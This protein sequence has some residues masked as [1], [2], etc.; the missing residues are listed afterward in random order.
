MKARTGVGVA[1]SSGS[2]LA[3]RT[4]PARRAAAPGVGVLAG[5]ATCSTG[6]STGWSTGCSTGCSSTRGSACRA[7][8]RSMAGTAARIVSSRE[9]AAG[10][11]VRRAW[12]S[13]SARTAWAWRRERDGA[14]DGRGEQDLRDLDLDLGLRRVDQSRLE[15]LQPAARVDG[16]GNLLGLRL[17]RLLADRAHDDGLPARRRLT[18][19][20]VAGS[21][22][23]RRVRCGLAD[24]EGRGR[25]DPRSDHRVPLDRRGR[26]SGRR[27]PARG[28][29]GPAPS[30]GCP[31]PTPSCSPCSAVCCSLWCASQRPNR[32]FDGASWRWGSAAMS[33]RYGD[34]SRRVTALPKVVRGACNWD[35][36][37][38]M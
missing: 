4:R 21:G 12:R 34:T 16:L 10:A 24:A 17:L 2:R 13:A 29:R 31:R 20:V 5:S 23:L 37:T 19:Q 14:G 26:D 25:C 6:C 30:P 28:A 15:P 9:R 11:W 3:P 38:R 27:Q 7:A 36:L 35:R 18:V 33:E 32:S 22:L 8:C 1:T